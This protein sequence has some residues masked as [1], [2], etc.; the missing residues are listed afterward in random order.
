MANK[1]KSFSVLT[2]GQIEKLS[3]IPEDFLDAQQVLY[4]GNYGGTRGTT[5]PLTNIFQL[6]W[7]PEKF[8]KLENV[9]FT[10][11][12]EY[13]P[14]STISFSQ[15]GKYKVFTSIKDVCDKALAN[16]ALAAD[17]KERPFVLPEGWRYQL[18]LKK[19]VETGGRWIPWVYIANSNIPGAGLGLFASSRIEKR[20]PIGVYMGKKVWTSSNVGFSVP[21]DEYLNSLP[22]F[23]ADRLLVRDFD[24]KYCVVEIPKVQEKQRTELYTGVHFAKQTGSKNTAIVE[25]AGFNG[26]GIVRAAQRIEKDGEITVPY[27]Q[28]GAEATTASDS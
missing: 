7:N 24:A 17:E 13:I 6:S 20:E 26:L 27:L 18:Y 15:G 8:I 10:W 11:Q 3:K 4:E 5:D 21:S 9:V 16:K 22:E 2:P 14:D 23:E 12:P 25:T 1:E 19:E 28:G